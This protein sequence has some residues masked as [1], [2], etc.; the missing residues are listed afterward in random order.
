MLRFLRST[1]GLSSDNESEQTHHAPSSKHSS[2]NAKSK[3]TPHSTTPGP[4]GHPAISVT[5]QNGD[6]KTPIPKSSAPPTTRI[7]VTDETAVK[8][9]RCAEISSLLGHL[10]NSVVDGVNRNLEDLRYCDISG[11]GDFSEFANRLNESMES[12]LAFS[13]SLHGKSEIL[14]SMGTIGKGDII[15]AYPKG[16]SVPPHMESQLE[17]FSRLTDRKTGQGVAEHMDDVVE[18]LDRILEDRFSKDCKKT[19]FSDFTQGVCLAAAR[20]EHTRRQACG[21]R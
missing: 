3:T 5:T 10:R 6:K 16:F 1:L 19:K 9:Q 7:P 21:Q 15:D 12:C 14:K 2:V 18:G 17:D 11:S 13:A 20:L 8:A 4:S